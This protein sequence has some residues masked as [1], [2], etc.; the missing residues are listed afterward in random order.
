MVPGLERCAPGVVD[1]GYYCR[2][3]ENRPLVGPLPVPG[4]FVIG[5]LSGFGVM[6]SQAAGELL[7]AHVMG[8]DLPAYAPAFRLERYD[9]PDYSPEAIAAEDGQL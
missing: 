4:T 8:T 2:T 7:A 6:A 5:A 9:D 1:G 3:P